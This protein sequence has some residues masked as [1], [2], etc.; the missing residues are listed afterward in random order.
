MIVSLIKWPL[1]LHSNVF[2]LRIMTKQ[3]FFIAIYD[4]FFCKKWRLIMFNHMVLW[5]A[6]NICSCGLIKR[7]KQ[8]TVSTHCQALCHYSLRLRG[9]AVV[10][11]PPSMADVTE[12]NPSSQVTAARMTSSRWASLWRAAAFSICRNQSV[13]HTY[14]RPTGGT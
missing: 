1:S 14:V 10:S 8:S 13:H 6:D 4:D 3:R 11:R 5:A 2:H 9:V 7:V 12:S